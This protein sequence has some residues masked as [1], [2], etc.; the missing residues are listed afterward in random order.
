MTVRTAAARATTIRIGGLRRSLG[1]MAPSAGI[2]PIRFLGSARRLLLTARSALSAPFFSPGAP[3]TSRVTPYTGV[4]SRRNP[5][6]GVARP[7][8]SPSHSVAVVP[9]TADRG[10]TAPESR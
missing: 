9:I 10:D 6:E 7:F 2:T 4:P 8:E 1:L 5:K 3:H